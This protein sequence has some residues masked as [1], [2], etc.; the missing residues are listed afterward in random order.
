MNGKSEVRTAIEIIDQLLGGNRTVKLIVEGS[1]PEVSLPGGATAIIPNTLAITASRIHCGV[2]LNVD[3][4]YVTIKKG[5]L[6]GRID[7]IDLM[8]SQID[9]SIRGLPDVLIEVDE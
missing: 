3:R 1:G 6:S 5:W 2:R 8:P 4:P 9:I 7:A